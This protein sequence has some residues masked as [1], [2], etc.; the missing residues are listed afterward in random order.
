M[1]GEPL[2]RLDDSRGHADGAEVQQTI[3][4]FA[5]V[6]HHRSISLGPR[7]GRGSDTDGLRSTPRSAQTA[8]TDTE[9][10]TTTHELSYAQTPRSNPFA[11]SI[12]IIISSSSSSNSR[13]R[14]AKFVL[15]ENN[16]R[17]RGCLQT[18]KTAGYLNRQRGKERE[19]IKAE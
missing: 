9:H 7:R 10:T 11:N 8:H 13:T 15:V 1:L 17:V 19:A 2:I 5:K 6:L 18:R 14:S 12:I 4:C 3:C 16:T